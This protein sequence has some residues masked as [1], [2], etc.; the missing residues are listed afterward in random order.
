MQVLPSRAE[1]AV[2]NYKGGGGR[3][4][5]KNKE[6]EIGLEISLPSSGTGD[7]Q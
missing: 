5:E 7:I 4:K 2:N 1:K 3:E 6:I